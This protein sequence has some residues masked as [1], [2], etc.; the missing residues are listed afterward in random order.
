MKNL[1]F[2]HFKKKVYSKFRKQSKTKH[3]L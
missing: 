2:Y 1:Y 3:T